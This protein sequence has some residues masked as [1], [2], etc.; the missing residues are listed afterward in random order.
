[1]DVRGS[2][3]KVGAQQTALRRAQG[4]QQ[5]SPGLWTRMPSDDTNPL[6]GN[7]CGCWSLTTELEENMCL[8]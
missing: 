1:M 3:G 8:F 4:K 7:F 5:P 2:Q 6:K